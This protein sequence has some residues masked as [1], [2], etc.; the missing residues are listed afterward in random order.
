MGK[1]DAAGFLQA[2]NL[3]FVDVGDK[4]GQVKVLNPAGEEHT[5]DLDRM[6]AS[7]GIKGAE[8]V[9]NT[10]D[11]PVERSPVG[12]MD[13]LKLSMGNAKGQ[14]AYLKNNYQD[15]QLRE[16]G[17]LIVKDKGA[18][19]TVDPRGLGDGTG[20]DIAKEL[21]GDVL[22]LGKDAVTTAGQ[23]AG[24]A[25]GV[26]GGAPGMVAGAAAGGGLASG[27]TIALGRIL[28]TYDATPQEM[29]RDV[30]L[31]TLLSAGG[32][33]VALGAKAAIVPA[34]KKALA[35]LNKAA[36]EV[37]SMV[38]S[39]YATSTGASESNIAR[40]IERP[41]PVNAELDSL[42][43]GAGAKADSQN[44]LRLSREKAIKAAEPLLQDAQKSLSAEWRSRVGDIVRTTPDELQIDA[45]QP[46]QKLCSR[47]V[48]LGSLSRCTDRRESSSATTRLALRKWLK[49]LR[50]A[51]VDE[52]SA[53]PMSKQLANW[54][55]SANN[56]LSRVP[57]S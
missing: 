18:W 19:Y 33:A 43:K 51:G 8:I 22:D 37:K 10:P 32:E 16:N 31:D 48:S 14:L 26:A 20:W 9:Y 17:D 30:A 4:P 2:N 49:S 3:Q 47:W 29:A 23:V 12:L 6:L 42:I 28:G 54:A 5:L 40:L 41:E 44:L 11:N 55:N 27:A 50:A 38:T 7:K 57:R 56:V 45:A 21:V 13:R 36:P 1:F 25:V 46:I 52:A 24:S 35:G 34:A 15:A 53:V 39:L